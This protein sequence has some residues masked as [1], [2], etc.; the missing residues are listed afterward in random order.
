MVN[1]FS[2][3]LLDLDGGQDGMAKNTRPCVVVSPDEMNAVLPWAIVAPLSAGD[4][5]RPTRV[6][7]DFLN[8]NRLVVLDQLRTVDSSR[9]VK[10]IGELDVPVRKLIAERLIE[11][12]SL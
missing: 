8:G 10:K 2:V 5:E 7:V 11:M 3:Y 9:L 12:F 1:R 6:V 4:R